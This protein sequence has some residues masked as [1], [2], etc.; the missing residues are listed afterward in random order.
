VRED[1][2]DHGRLGDAR[3][4]AQRRATPR[5]AQRVDLEDPTQQRRPAT[6]GFGARASESP[7]VGVVQRVCSWAR[8]HKSLS[9]AQNFTPGHVFL[10]SRAQQQRPH[11]ILSDLP[12]E[13][14]THKQVASL[15]MT[16]PLAL[17]EMRGG[18]RGLVTPTS[19]HAVRVP[20][21]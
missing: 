3:D 4:D 6:A 21:I 11:V 13:R 18:R 1:P 7:K 14:K 16:S 5:T 9:S 20:L 12:F 2:G 8:H 10:T 17:I 19:L 15:R